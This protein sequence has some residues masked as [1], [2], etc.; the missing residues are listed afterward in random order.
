MPLTHMG[1]GDA[2]YERRFQYM[3]GGKNYIKTGF[4]YAGGGARHA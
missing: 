4:G 3:A 2:E 1:M